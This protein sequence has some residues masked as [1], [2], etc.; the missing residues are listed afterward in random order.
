[1]RTGWR[2]LFTNRCHGDA[3]NHSC[4]PSHITHQHMTLIMPQEMTSSQPTA[5]GHAA[6]KQREIFQS[7][8]KIVI[9]IWLKITKHFYFD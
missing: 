2:I 7:R 8:L 4:R 1:M 6:H 5:N 3:V 9:V